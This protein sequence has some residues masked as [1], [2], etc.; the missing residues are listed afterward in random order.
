M[1]KRQVEVFTAGCSVCEPA[2]QMVNELTCPDCAITVYNL[3]D[4]GAEK[5]EQYG[6]KTLPAVVVDGSLVSCCD[7]HGPNRQE[8]SAAGI[9][10]PLE[11][12]RP[13]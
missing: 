2:V 4:A 5:A 11:R 8:L 13:R 12:G 1:S 10:M 9:G 3:N 6:V 7:N